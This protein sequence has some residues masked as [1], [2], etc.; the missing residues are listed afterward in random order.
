MTR[1]ASWPSIAYV[2]AEPGAGGCGSWAERYF[3][4][5]D[6][7]DVLMGSGNSAA[8]RLIISPLL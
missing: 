1:D 3:M 4:K 2:R 7:P 8:I 6:I 5:W